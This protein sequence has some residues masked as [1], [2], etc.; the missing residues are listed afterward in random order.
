MK[1]LFSILLVLAILLSFSNVTAFAEGEEELNNGNE[2]SEVIDNGSEQSEV[3]ENGNEQNVTIDG[4]NVQGETGTETNGNGDNGSESNIA[5]HSVMMQLESPVIGKKPTAP[6][7]I[8]YGEETTTNVTVIDYAWEKV[9]YTEWDEQ[10]TGTLMDATETF[11]GGY[12]Y[13][14]YVQLQC[15]EGY[16]FFGEL[17]VYV[18]GL[19]DNP[20]RNGNATAKDKVWVC[21]YV[22]EDLTKVVM[23]LHATVDAPKYGEIV[24]Q[25]PYCQFELVTVPEKGKEWIWDD[26]TYCVW[27]KIAEKDYKGTTEDRWILMEDEEKFTYG[28]YY[29]VEFFV[30]IHNDY[31]LYDEGVIGTVN[32][33]DH[34]DLYG[35]VYEDSTHGYLCAV[36][37]PLE[38]PNK[39]PETGDINLIYLALASM[40]LSGVTIAYVEK[41][42][43]K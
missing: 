39:V 30:F 8:P 36:F 18:E 7:V 31:V 5:V 37:A 25:N 2:Q 6:T 22:Y 3:I 9:L 4:G 23:E 40:A 1:R 17:N 28:Y 11:T 13:C 43:K 12:Y 38:D 20:S 27:Y 10:S 41:K 29:M 26:D 42:R 33:K 19:E 34:Y 35:P 32:G 15:N 16:E 21:L 14:I 24:H